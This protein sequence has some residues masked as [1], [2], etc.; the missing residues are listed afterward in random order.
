MTFAI[1]LEPARGEAMRASGLW[2]GRL[3]TDD[4]DEA[5]RDTPDAL[6]IVAHRTEGGEVRLTWRELGDAVQRIAVALAGLGVQ[7]GQVVSFQLPNWWQFVAV[8]LACV[9]IGAV[10]NPMVPI[11]RQR[12]LRFMLR[13]AETRVMIVPS[14]YR[15]FDYGAMMRELRGDLPDLKRVLLVGGE[16]DESFEQVLLAPVGDAAQAQALLRKRRP[17]PDD[18]TQVMYTSGTTGEPKGVMHT[19]DTLVGGAGCFIR[20]IRLTQEHRVLMASPLGHQSGFLYGMGVALALKTTLVL[21][22]VWNPALAADLIEREG[23]GYTFASSPFLADLSNGADARKLRTL[24]YF[25]CSGAPIPGPL[26]E[27][28]QQLGFRVLAGWGMTENGIVTV[29]R[30]E[31]AAETSVTTDGRAIEGME[32]RVVG[33]DGEPLAPGQVGELE[34]RG[35]ALFVGYLKR[36]SGR[37]HPLG[38]IPHRRPGADGRTRLVA[39]GAARTCHP[40]GARTFR[41]EVEALL[42]RHPAVQI[43]AIVAYPDDRLGE[44]AC[45]FVVPRP[46]ATVDLGSIVS[47]LK[48][49]QLAVQYI[50]ERVEV[51]DA[52][53]S[54]PSGKVQKFR[55]RE[56]LREARP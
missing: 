23:V 25:V 5:L 49:Q 8:Y 37:Q 10:A 54:T 31:D 21:Q 46:G 53:P 20:S 35:A 15:G 34:A 38:W 28:A 12:E 43:A 26:V 55:L 45:A 32:V 19:H 1:Q 33:E 47:F 41:V 44:R 24:R 14:R 22:D 9:R 7:P 48:E 2:P 29:V 40:R 18:L 4:L 13:F 3:F 42:Y 17:A 6:A 16:G 11:F 30:P 56:L 50:P 27:R 36:P 39:N 51:R 52:L